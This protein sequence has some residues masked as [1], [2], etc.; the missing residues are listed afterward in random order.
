MTTESKLQVFQYKILHR[1]IATKESL[2]RWNIVP[3]PNYPDCQ[4]QLETVEHML[5]QCPK[6]K[7]LWI[8]VIRTMQE[9]EKYKPEV[10]TNTMLLGLTSKRKEIRKWNYMALLT[11]FYIYRCRLNSKSI[12][13]QSCKAFLQYKIGMHLSDFE[14]RSQ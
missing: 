11:K 5:L 8:N 7:D 14:T 13:W 4:S 10:S 2:Y 9:N 3:S 12:N 1:V 6:T